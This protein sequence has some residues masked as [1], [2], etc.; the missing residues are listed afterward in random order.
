MNRTELIFG[1]VNYFKENGHLRNASLGF[2]APIVLFKND[3]NILQ[4]ENVLQIEKYYQFDVT[5]CEYKGDVAINVYQ[6]EYHDLPLSVL[7][8]IH[9]QIE[10]LKDN[11]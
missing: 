9:A 5:I 6:Q 10:L 4:V 2:D 8:I 7:E 11:S 1:I 3:D